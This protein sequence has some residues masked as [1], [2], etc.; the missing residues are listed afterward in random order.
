MARIPSTPSTVEVDITS[1]CNLR[2]K[3]CSHFTSA[4]DV[5]QDLP[6]EEWI[7][8]FNELNRCAV[9]RVILSGGEPFCRQDLREIIEGIV[10]NRMRFAIVSNGTLIDHS[11]AAFLAS[12]RRCDTVQVSID[13]SNPLPHDSFRGQGSFGGAMG[14][15]KFLQE[16]HVP[17]TAR[18]TIHRQ[19]IYDLE[20][21]A[22]LLL[23]ELGLPSF[24]TNSA[25]PMG[26]CRFNAEL[27]ELNPA[28][29][30]YAMETLLTLEQ[31]Y[32]G[33]ILAT[34]GP[35]AD[36]K[37]WLGWGRTSR[38]GP[39]PLGS[40]RGHLSGCAAGIAKMAV[41]ADGVMT[42]C[43]QISHIELG[44]INHDD[45]Q[46]IW[47]EHPRLQEFRK[48]SSIQLSSF[49]FCRGCNLIHCCTGNCPALAWTAF[50][51][52]NHPSPSGCLKRFL[53]LG[54]TLP[55][56]PQAATRRENEH[57]SSCP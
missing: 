38:S 39:D 33:R 7:Q 52:L 43:G 55:R 26:L 19:N 9:L 11:I 6:K 10:K 17:V 50:G 13:G 36:A 45:L 47:Q 34:A 18:V 25:G 40:R 30:S 1:Q 15:I 24:S 35:L 12:T 5:A 42:P 54:G 2:C 21:I 31:K 3:Y 41:R 8:F 32:R 29:Y 14:G 23:D 37:S 4:S 46:A 20:R 57:E 49:E 48:R 16:N 56:L 51:S 44:R 27:L 22:W 53:E 28:E